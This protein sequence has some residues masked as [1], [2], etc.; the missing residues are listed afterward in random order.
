LKVHLDRLARS[1]GRAY[2]DTDPV[3]FV[4]RYDR[5]EDREVVG[6]I[7]SALAFGN[8][9]QILRSVGAVLEILEAP[10]HAGRPQAALLA[11]APTE[12]ARRLDGFRHRFV[13]GRDVVALLLAVRRAH[14]SHGSLGRLF[15]AGFRSGDPDIREGLVRFVD[16]LLEVDVRPVYGRKRI[17][18]EAG[19]RY[20]LPNP[21]DG[22][23]C[24]RLNLFLRWMVR[25]DA[26]DPGVW[27]GVS[28]A[29]LLLPLDTHT[30][31]I[32]RHLGLTRLRTTNWR[33][34]TDVTASLRRLD[35][36]DPV[37]YDFALARLGILDLC[38]KRR[39]GERCAR[40]SLEPVC[41]L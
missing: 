19:V 9:P 17:P 18:A 40:C 41:V 21:R 25:R 38:P 30:S 7:A 20:L 12:L 31:R 35:P 24:K 13:S 39:D 23:A 16:R 33:M 32:S 5:P 29:K 6:M 14:E 10:P 15:A 27:E 4:H 22:S 37:R 36:A 26:I 8:I 3:R 34:A 28:P 11:A 1:Y 2:L